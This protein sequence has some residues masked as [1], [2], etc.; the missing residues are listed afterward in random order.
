MQIQLLIIGP[1]R[2]GE[3]MSLKPDFSGVLNAII[4][5]E[6]MLSPQ[7][8]SSPQ[9]L[10][11]SLSKDSLFNQWQKEHPKNFLSHFFAALDSDFKF[12]SNWEIGFFAEDKITVFLPLKSEFSTSG[13]PVEN[14]GSEETAPS[15]PRCHSGRFPIDKG[16]EIKPADEIFKQKSAKLESLNLKLVVLSYEEAL[17]KFQDSQLV[18]FPKVVLG[19]GFVILQTINGKILWNFTFIT[20]QLKF[21]NLKINALTG[22]EEDHQ[23]IDLVQKN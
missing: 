14:S 12:K 13:T 3:Q 10:V 19:D 15:Q 4:L 6:N 18:Y 7:A 1:S 21:V 9:E 8:L 17:K 5:G 2:P 20:K 22:K 16:F 11:Q 23:E